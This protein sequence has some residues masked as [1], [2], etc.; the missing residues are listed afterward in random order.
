MDKKILFVIVGYFLIFVALWV[1]SSKK[2][3]D[4][5]PDSWWKNFFICLFWPILVSG[6]MTLLE[7]IKELM[8]NKSPEQQ[9]RHWDDMAISLKYW[10]GENLTGKEVKKRYN[11]ISP[12][13]FKFYAGS[14]IF[15]IGS[16]I[17]IMLTALL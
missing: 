12:S 17:L 11:E 1:K 10:T 2:I 13:T 7:A 9:E 3:D 8:G 5:E 4:K 16:F 6:I 14:C 15:L